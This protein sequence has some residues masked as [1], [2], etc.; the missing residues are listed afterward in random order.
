MLGG[1]RAEEARLPVGWLV[2]IGNGL[3]EGTFGDCVSVKSFGDEIK[4]NVAVIK[5]CKK[6]FGVL[7]LRGVTVDHPSTVL[8]Y[9]VLPPVHD[10]SDAG[11]WTYPSSHFWPVMK[12]VW[13]GITLM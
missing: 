3:R 11:C 9:T 6:T 12:Q 13:Y 1:P 5:V 10:H 8:Q 2:G 7:F 4:R